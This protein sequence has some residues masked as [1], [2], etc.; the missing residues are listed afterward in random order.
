MKKTLVVLVSLTLGPTAMA[1]Y[2]VDA[3][4][5]GKVRLHGMTGSA[6]AVDIYSGSCGYW[7]VETAVVGSLY[8][9]VTIRTT[10]T[11]CNGNGSG[12]QNEVKHVFVD[13]Y[14]FRQ[15]HFI[16]TASSYDRTCDRCQVGD[17]GGT[18]GVTSPHSHLQYDKNGTLVTSWISP[19]LVN[20]QSV[21]GPIGYLP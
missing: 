15:W 12:N 4:F 11:V 3:P 13:G 14:T 21:S 17:E 9:N 10:G 1:G 20:G 8:W 16:Q 7:G 6:S 2:R 19:D 5:P 18:G